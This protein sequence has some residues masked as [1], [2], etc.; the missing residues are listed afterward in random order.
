MKTMYKLNV[1][2]TRLQKQQQVKTQ[3]HL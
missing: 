3:M 1:S 2:Q